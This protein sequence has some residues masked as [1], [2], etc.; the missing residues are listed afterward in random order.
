MNRPLPVVDDSNRQYWQGAQERRLV[1][2]RCSACRLWVHPPREMCPRCRS[3]HFAFE[4]VSGRGRV[5]SWSVM[6]S[7]GNPGFDERLPYAVLVV[8]LE[9][10]PGLFTIGNVVD[11][12]LDAIA[13]G[14]PVE[15]TWEPLTDEVTLPQWRP[16]RAPEPSP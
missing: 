9:E 16:A 12:P 13:I 3:E 14:M 10:Q 6:R 8:E 1:I 5:Y 4:Q 2:A 11:C 7:P 15:V